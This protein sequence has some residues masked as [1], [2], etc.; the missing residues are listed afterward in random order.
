M[1]LSI[2]LNQMCSA[3][4][5]IDTMKKWVYLKFN[6]YLDKLNIHNLGRVEIHN[7]V[8]P[9]FSC[10]SWRAEAG[11]TTQLRRNTTGFNLFKQCL[12]LLMSYLLGET[13]HVIY[14]NFSNHLLTT[15][16]HKNSEVQLSVYFTTVMK[17]EITILVQL[18][19]LGRAAEEH[20]MFCI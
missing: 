15:C 8:E 10:V 5:K 20:C 12:L 9:K 14:Q 16:M 11:I 2:E 3:Y 17:L 1:L 13:I 18:Q 6:T 19:E 7:G 4:Y